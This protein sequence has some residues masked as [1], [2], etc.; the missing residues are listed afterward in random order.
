MSDKG[1]QRRIRAMIRDLRSRL[2]AWD[3]IGID[4][5]PDECDCLHGPITHA[6]RGGASADA[7][8]QVLHDQLVD[9]FGLGADV[10]V[11]E[12]AMATEL[13]AWF[14]TWTLPSQ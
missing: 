12:A 4:P 5:P 7:L 13:V 2:D 6:L 9:H 10:D 3:P 14:R 11:G 1:E 8:A